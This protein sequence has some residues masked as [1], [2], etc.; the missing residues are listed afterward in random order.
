M[1][2]MNPSRGLGGADT[3]RMEQRIRWR[4]SPLQ[5]LS[6]RAFGRPQ[7]VLGKL[8]GVIMA[9]TNRAI[10]AR[11]VELLN[12]EPSDRVLEVG[13]GP[14][15]GIQLLEEMVEQATARNAAAVECGRVELQRGSVERLPFA[16]ETF[17]KALAINSMQIWP[18]PVAALRQMQL[19]LK[20]GGTIALAFTPYSGQSK[21]GLTEL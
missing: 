4:S 21:E 16:N 6:M 12:I 2:A 3:L 17:D 15:V 19:M 9:R 14:G 13:F 5:N 10:A 11:V 8:G 1:A 7:G 18:D 20:P